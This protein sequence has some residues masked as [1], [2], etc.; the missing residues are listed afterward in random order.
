M[1]EIYF[2]GLNMEKGKRLSFPWGSKHEG[3]NREILKVPLCFSFVQ[4]V[5]M[6]DN[7]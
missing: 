1:N 3:S 6:L 5:V 7:V 2:F 4:N